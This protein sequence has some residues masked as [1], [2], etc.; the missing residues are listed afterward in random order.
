MQNLEFSV[1]MKKIYFLFGDDD[2]LIL[3]RVREITSQLNTVQND[4]LKT[5]KLELHN[6]ED[7]D[8]FYAQGSNMSLFPENSVLIIEINTKLFKHIDKECTDFVNLIS[9]ILV[10]KTILLVFSLEKFDKALIKLIKESVF[11]KKLSSVATVQEF[12]KLKY[13]QVAEIKERVKL[14]AKNN[15]IQFEENALSLFVECFKEQL[16]YV[17]SELQKLKTCILPQKLVTEKLV[18]ELYFSGFNIDDLYSFIL[19]S[20]QDLVF[21][22]LDQLL[23][24]KSPIYLIA[25]LQNK[26]RQALQIKSLLES[27]TPVY[28]MSKITG[29]NSYKTEKLKS[30][31]KNIS[32]KRIQ[33]ILEVLSNIEF[34]TKTGVV[35]PQDAMDMILIKT[36]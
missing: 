17:S 25:S 1:M 21:S 9:S 16:E 26:F 10:Y 29:I 22:L 4:S 34:K 20:K 27:N 7:L 15:D 11:Y 12:F 33:N 35:A 3:D 5:E 30:E 24:L 6:I 36:L 31:L 14:L 8:S 13:W 18:E 32:L 2:F 23:K 28:Q 19:Y